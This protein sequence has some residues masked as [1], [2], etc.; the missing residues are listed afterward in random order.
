VI[1]I[2][3][4]NNPNYD[5]KKAYLVRHPDRRKASCYNYRLKNKDVIDYK[6]RLPENKRNKR[7]DEIIKAYGVTFAK[8]EEMKIQQNNKCAICNKPFV[9]S[10]HTHIDHNHKTG[11]IRQLLCRDCNVGLGNFKEDVEVMKF[12]INYL[13]RWKI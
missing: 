4:K 10:K 8:Y 13:E 6:R 1:N 2:L 12:A 7:E 9:S 11:T 3:D 5:Y